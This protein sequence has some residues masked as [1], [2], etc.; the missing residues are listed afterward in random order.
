MPHIQVE[1]RASGVTVITLDRP[2]KRNAINAAMAVELQDAFERFDQS[3]QRVVVLTGRGDAAFCGGA[4]VSDM[5]EFW[6]VVPN[7]GIQTDKPIIVALSGWCVGGAMVI[8]MLA[9][10]AVASETTQF[11]YPEAKLGLT[12]GMIA[13]LAARIPHKVAMEV[14]LLGRPL[15]AQ[16]AYDVGLVND[17]VPAGK[18]LEAAIAMAEEL[19][20]FA[21]MVLA[22][23]KRFVNHEIVTLSPAEQ[24]ARTAHALRAIDMSADK[25]EGVAAFLEKRKPRYTGK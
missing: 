16:R 23:L 22:T 24:A 11:L 21:P 6:R 8:S 15:S 12:G 17:V 13:G 18:H 14:M 25:K 3:E 19:A 1:N 5:P 10:L 4:D 20:G 7:V 9:D 2:E